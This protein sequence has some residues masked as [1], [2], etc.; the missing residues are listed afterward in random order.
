MT[1]SPSG[2]RVGSHRSVARKAW[3][4]SL[5]ALLCLAP[6][7]AGADGLPAPGKPAL[8]LSGR[9]SPRFEPNLGQAD[10]QVQFLARGRG[11]TLFLT[12]DEAVLALT[13]GPGDAAVVRMSLVDA[14][15]SP[16]VMGLETLPGIV[17]YFIGNDPARWRTSIPTYARVK[18]ESVYRGIDLVY[19]GSQGVLEYDFVVAPGAD[20]RM[21]TL[22]F[23]GADTLTVNSR[24]D[25]V[26][27][28]N[29]GELRL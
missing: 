10:P 22:A 3:L 11:H 25:L 6:A 14:Q 1:H 7:C 27:R 5:L 13:R 8:E 26:L 29:G 12:R 20:P 15:P 2:P 9:L 24:D 23:E 4:P 21:I 28:T 17:N 18:Y 19:H 16:R